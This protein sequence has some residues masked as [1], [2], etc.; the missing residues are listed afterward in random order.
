[1]PGKTH[2]EHATVMKT[3]TRH[4]RGWKVTL[5]DCH[6]HFVGEVVFLLIEALGCSNTT[7]EQYTELVQQFG[8]AVVFRGSEDAC[9][10]VADKLGSTGLRV[11]VDEA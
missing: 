11:E 7:A 5:F 3:T 4:D 9:K 8:Q 2:R 6:C 1:M 10:H